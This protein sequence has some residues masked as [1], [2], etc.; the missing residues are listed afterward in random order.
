VSRRGRPRVDRLRLLERIAPLLAG[1]PSLSANRVQAVVGGRR[2]DV[3]RIVAAL[4]AAL[5]PGA[6]PGR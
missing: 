1:D 5:P 3:L 6:P 2:A 4:R